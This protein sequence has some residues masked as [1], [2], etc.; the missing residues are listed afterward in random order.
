MRTRKTIIKI[1]FFC[2][3]RV[4]KSPLT[5]LEMPMRP[6]MWCMTSQ[7]LPSKNSVRG[8]CI[9]FIPQEFAPFRLW[10]T[11][12]NAEISLQ[13][14][15]KKIRKTW[16]N[17]IKGFYLQLMLYQYKFERSYEVNTS[18]KRDNERENNLRYM[19]FLCILD[20]LTY[21]LPVERVLARSTVITMS[22]N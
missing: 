18:E 1:H 17:V 7:N 5:I 3:L 13:L 20:H 9:S 15:I 21:R 8:D 10:Y 2:V 11:L 19:P 14:L 16:K 12:Y 22:C 6:Y 4:R